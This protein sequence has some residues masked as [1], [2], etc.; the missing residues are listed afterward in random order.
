MAKLG[1][2]RRVLLAL[3]ALVVSGGLGVAGYRALIDE[4]ETPATL[5]AAAAAG[6]MR[7]PAECAGEKNP[8]Q[9]A[10]C[11][12][13]YFRKVAREGDVAATLQDVENL[14]NEGVLDDCHALAHHFGHIVMEETGDLTRAL[15]AGSDDCFDGYYHGVVEAHVHHIGD[16]QAAFERTCARLEDDAEAFS[17]CVHGLGHGAMLLTDNDVGASLDY[18]RE[19]NG[20]EAIDRCEGGVMMQNTMQ[21]MHEDEAS[22][23]AAAPQACEGLSLPAE[24]LGVCYE[25][26]GEVSMFFYQHD[27]DQAA[28]LCA[29][30]DS[31]PGREECLEGAEHELELVEQNRNT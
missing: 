19:L 3:L 15:E 24:L 7:E 9:R 17:A 20:D 31:A 27:L 11:S 1:G 25:Q 2:D 23:R 29:D 16:D 6:P 22:F 4:P 28:A 12:A 5:Q 8:A 13:P 21:F 18:C 14:F 10:T 26:I 30:I